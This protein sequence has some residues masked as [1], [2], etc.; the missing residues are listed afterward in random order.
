MRVVIFHIF[1]GR[2]A[3]VVFGDFSIIEKTATGAIRKPVANKASDDNGLLSAVH[4]GHDSTQI[5]DLKHLNKI[6]DWFR[7]KNRASVFNA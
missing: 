2:E 3:L 6:F 1:Q 4:Q 7:S 5:R